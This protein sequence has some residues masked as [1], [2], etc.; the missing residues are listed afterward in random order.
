MSE[1]VSAPENDQG[2]MTE[3]NPADLPAEAENKEVPDTVAPV[4]AWRPLMLEQ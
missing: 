4:I 2:S 3:L 1:S